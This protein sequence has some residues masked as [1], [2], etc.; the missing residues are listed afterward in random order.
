MYEMT[1]PGGLY[2]HVP[3]CHAK[4]AYCDFYS[5]PDV[6]TADA[7]VDAL[8]AEARL[9][10]GE[11]EGPVTTLYIGGG[12]PS[13]L[14]GGR[15]AKLAGG[16]R[17][18]FDLDAVGE[19]T[20]EVNPEDVDIELIDALLGIGV[21]RVSMGVQ[22]LADDELKRIGRRHTSAEAVKAARLIAS[23]FE[24]FSL[25]IIFGLPGQTLETLGASLDRFIEFDAPHLS[26]YL[27]S[28]EPGTR[29][30]SQLIAGKVSETT[31]EL[32]DAMYNLVDRRFSDAGYCHYEISNYARPGFE[33]RH[34]SAYWNG[35][36][37]LGLGP[38]AHSY[39]GD[40][41]RYNPAGV[42]KYIEALAAGHIFYEVDEETIENKFNDYLITRLRTARGLDLDDL[43]AQPYGHLIGK[44]A[45]PLQ[46]LGDAG[47]IVVNGKKV[48]IPRHRWLTSDAI[49]R[50][51]II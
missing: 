28:Y 26:A 49:L 1:V 22:S 41:R 12:T 25:D 42:R 47:L 8:L 34:N 16:L 14:G 5:T 32:A 19:F 17:Q 39:D 15:L 44:I 45:V 29:L 35:T 24:N 10:R 40:V 38:S 51:L 11:L 2:I 50:E 30:Y 23:A 18:V 4:C 21:N 9:R 27:L 36:R 7:F 20:V 33:S 46:R 13:L 31:E 3:Y 37:Y 48:T 6:S 43:V